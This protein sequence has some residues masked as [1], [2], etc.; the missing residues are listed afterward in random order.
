MNR[1]HHIEIKDNGKSVVTPVCKVLH[2]LKP[3]LEK[4]LKQMVD[5]GIEL[6]KKPTDWVNG[7]VIT[8]K[9]NEKLHICLDPQPLNNAIKCEHLHLPTDKEIVS[10]MS[11]ACFFSKLDASSGYW[12]IK[13]DEESSHPSAF[14]TP[15]GHY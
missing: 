2:V 5:L 4:E 9:P 13:L 14:G 15:L 7:L 12:Q 6:K 8:K 1:T 3:K 11:V 10:K